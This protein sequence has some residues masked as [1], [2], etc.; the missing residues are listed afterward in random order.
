MMRM[1]ELGGMQGGEDWSKTGKSVSMKGQQGCRLDKDNRE[2]LRRNFKE[3][4]IENSLASSY[5]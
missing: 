2:H 4:G 3:R 5:L 1:S